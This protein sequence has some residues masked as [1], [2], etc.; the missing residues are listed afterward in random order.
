MIHWWLIAQLHSHN[1]R[2]GESR[3][4]DNP[5]SWARKSIWI[6]T[7]QKEDL[8]RIRWPLVLKPRMHSASM[9]KNWYG[10]KKSRWNMLSSPC[11]I[12]ISLPPCLFP[13][14]S[15]IFNLF[16]SISCT[17]SHVHLFSLKPLS[18]EQPS[19]RGTPCYNVAVEK[20]STSRHPYMLSFFYHNSQGTE[21]WFFSP[22]KRKLNP[23]TVTTPTHSNADN[24]LQEHAQGENT[25]LRMRYKCVVKDMQDTEHAVY[26]VLW[27]VYEP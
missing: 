21:L 24:T 15:T 1:T 9:S 12:N 2:G 14:L 3:G 11:S 8:G 10:Q 16:T 5:R 26:T 7:F 25:V 20:M 17:Y 27:C 13:H 19:S 18:D 22:K 4:K 23:K 6:T